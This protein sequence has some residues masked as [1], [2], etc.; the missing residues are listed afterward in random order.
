MNFR[1][2]KSSLLKELTFLQGAVERKSSI[3]ILQNVHIS[4]TSGG[5]NLRATDL[6]VH[7]ATFADA[8]IDGEGS[9]CIPAKRFHDIVKALPDAEITIT[10]NDTEAV[11]KCQRSRFR[12][13]TA[14]PDGYPDKRTAPSSLL[15][16]SASILSTMIDRVQFAASKE[17]SRYALN[18]VKFELAEGKARMIATDSHRM[19]YI[20]R[21]VYYEGAP[22]DVLI[23]A[24]T[25][26]LVSKLASSS[27][28][29]SIGYEETTIFFEV[30]KRVI[31]SRV[32]A[33][34]FPNYRLVMA[35]HPE[36]I[37]V[38]AQEFASA[39]RRVALVADA[40]SSS[41]KLTMNR[42]LVSISAASQDVGDAGEDVPSNVPEALIGQSIGIKAGYVADF[43][44]AC[45][46]TN[47]TID[48]KDSASQIVMRP[49]DDGDYDYQYIVMPMR[50]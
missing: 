36:R 11:I 24:K 30:G 29:I 22:I 43:F 47:L 25:L 12:L 46:T 19:A 31:A 42:D 38:N 32:L 39:L 4:S 13:S 49:T 16:I 9:A 5:L 20:E 34:Q 23:P 28:T 2:G 15:P 50:I 17:E 45:S 40:Q 33:G 1:I 8:T 26:D 41:V 3:P 37:A 10:T 44:D 18:G 7:I 48:Y 6:D 35:N 27:D 14:H 21:D